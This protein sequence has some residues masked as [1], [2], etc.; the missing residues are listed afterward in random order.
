MLTTHE[1][2]AK[3]RAAF[4]AIELLPEH[5]I[6][7]LGTGA[8]ANLFIEAMAERVRAGRRLI[9]VP[10]SEAS[11]RKAAAFGIELLT[12]DGPWAVD[13]CV[14]GADEVS[15][16]LD[17][18]KGGG[19]CH[20]REKIVNHAAAFNVIVAEEA[21]LSE[22]L[23]ERRA[24]PV[25][26]VP[27]GYQSTVRQLRR[28]GEAQI[29]MRDGVHWR[30]DSGNLICDVHFGPI[31]DPATLDRELVSLPGVVETGLFCARADVVI[32]GTRDG[33]RQLRRTQPSS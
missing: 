5:G 10:T 28:W 19:G 3:Q 13:V 27:F 15:A 22:R 18:I 20:T 2:Q 31:A 30:T 17:L 32:L 26:I 6:I 16:A 12:D 14:D 9:G 8:T 1:D 23:G 11:R 29:R 7:G 21:K 25:E 24:V 33:T 4:A